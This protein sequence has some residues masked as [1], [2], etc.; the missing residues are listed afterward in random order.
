MRKLGI[1]RISRQTVKNILKEAGLDPESKRGTGSWDEFLKMHADTLWQCD[2][3]SVK[4]LTLT[5]F[6]DLYL[7]AFLQIGTRRAW[8]SPCTAHPDSA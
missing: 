4:S 8:N 6:V 7:L 1:T 3:L 2:F 5:G